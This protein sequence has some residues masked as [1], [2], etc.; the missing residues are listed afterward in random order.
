MS[1]KEFFRLTKGKLIF[2]DAIMVINFYLSFVFSTGYAGGT[3][4]FRYSDI[5]AFI[6]LSLSANLSY[7]QVLAIVDF[8]GNKSILWLP[9]SLILT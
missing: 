9:V 6:L 7:E 3:F 4:Q 1:L 2:F 5:F 8:F